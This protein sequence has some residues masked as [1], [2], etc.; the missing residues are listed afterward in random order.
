[1]DESLYIPIKYNK[2]RPNREGVW[3]GVLVAELERIKGKLI[4]R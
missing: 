1:M 3:Y 4:N 2:K